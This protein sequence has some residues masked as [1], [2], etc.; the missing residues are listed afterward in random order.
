MYCFAGSSPSCCR[1]TIRH[2]AGGGGGERPGEILS[3]ERGLHSFICSRAAKPVFL[4]APGFRHLVAVLRHRSLFP[5]LSTLPALSTQSAIGAKLPGRPLSDTPPAPPFL[6]DVSRHPLL[7]LTLAT[8]TA[9]Y[10]VYL[11]ALYSEVAT[12]G[13]WSTL[14]RHHESPLFLP[15]SPNM[16][17]GIM[18][19]THPYC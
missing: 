4:R 7:S 19:P 2:S 17:T 18:L 5:R 8:S 11:L 1:S 10:V 15:Q 13:F 14:L 16:V 3:V 6:S 12:L 9:F